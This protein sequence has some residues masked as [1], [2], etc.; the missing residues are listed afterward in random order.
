MSLLHTCLSIIL[1]LK[2]KTHK[3]WVHWIIVLK[4]IAFHKIKCLLS[5]VPWEQGFYPMPLV[6]LYLL[7]LYVCTYWFDTLWHFSPISFLT[8]R[9]KSSDVI[10]LKIWMYLLCYTWQN[11]DYSHWNIAYTA[12]IKWVPLKNPRN[13]YWLMNDN[14]EKAFRS[15]KEINM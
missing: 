14:A 15:M 2:K 1:Q 3:T 9:N 6:N 8:Q 4:L 12:K 11:I 10:P 7:Y 5:W 13:G